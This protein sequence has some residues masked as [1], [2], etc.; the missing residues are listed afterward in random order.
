M[1]F[2]NVDLQ[3]QV[4]TKRDTRI[5]I[6]RDISEVELTASEAILCH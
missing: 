6:K 1:A 4:V 5:N 3:Q 2:D